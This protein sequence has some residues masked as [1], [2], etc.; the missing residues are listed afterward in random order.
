GQRYGATIKKYNLMNNLLNGL[1]KE[2][3]SRRHI[4]NMYQ[5]DDFNET[6]GLYPCAYETI[7]SVRENNN[8]L[9]LDLTLI[10]GSNDYIMA[11]YI[12]KIQ[13]VVLQMMVCGHLGYKPGKFCHF[14]EN[15]HIYDRHFDALE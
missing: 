1:E 14:V 11:G 13:Y 5:Y 4:I 10:Q 9:I 15:L 3:F 12:N 8:N 6:S 2:P 7:W